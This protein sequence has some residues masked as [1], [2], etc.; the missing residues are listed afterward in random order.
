MFNFSVKNL[1]FRNT[2]ILLIQDFSHSEELLFAVVGARSWRLGTA[3]S[4]P[5]E[6]TGRQ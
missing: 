3:D 1:E 2:Q 4:G 5:S 6:A